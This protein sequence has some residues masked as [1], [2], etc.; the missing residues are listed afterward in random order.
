V[1]DS[2]TLR[3]GTSLLQVLANQ[4]AS[5]IDRMASATAGVRRRQISFLQ[6]RCVFVGGSI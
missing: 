2:L 1:P 5:G 6:R 3:S 4:I